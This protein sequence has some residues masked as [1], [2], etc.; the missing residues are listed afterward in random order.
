VHM[1]R[2]RHTRTIRVRGSAIQACED[3]TI[4]ELCV[5]VEISHSTEGRDEG[6]TR[7]CDGR[8]EH[9][10]ERA[11]TREGERRKKVTPKWRKEGDGKGDVRKR[12]DG[13]NEENEAHVGRRIECR[14]G[15]ETVG[16]VKRDGKRAGGQGGW[17]GEGGRGAR[18]NPGIYA[19]RA[20]YSPPRLHSASDYGVA[21]GEEHA[22]SLA[23]RLIWR[24]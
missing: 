11:R 21:L 15:E 19:E 18:K 12:D 24:C 17:E 23:E 8:T 6:S 10:S 14:G 9:T 5:I 2:D 4:V 7:R 3:K 20:K 1:K 16:R 13:R 22:P